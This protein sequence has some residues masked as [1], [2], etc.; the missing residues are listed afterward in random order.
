MNLHEGSGEPVEDSVP[1]S[2]SAAEAFE[3]LPITGAQGLSAVRLTRV[4]AAAS[5]AAV[6]LVLGE[7]PPQR[8]L[9][10]VWDDGALEVTLPVG[11]LDHLTAAG[12]LLETVDG[13]LGPAREGRSFVMRVPVAGTRAMYLML[14]QGTISLAVPWHSVIRIRLIETSGLE[15]MARREGCPVLP[16]FV[17]VPTSKA[18]R[19]AVLVALG[20][21]RG[22]LLA[23]RLVWRMPGLATGDTGPAPGASLG[24]SVRTAGGE[25][26]WVVDP[27]RLLKDVEPAPLPSS[28]IVPRRPP[29]RGQE[30]GASHRPQPAARPRPVEPVLIE[31]RPEDVEPIPNPT[32]APSKQTR[33]ARRAL[34]VEDSIVGRIFL[35]RLLVAQGFSV[36][37]ASSASQLRHAIGLG[38]WD[39]LFVDVA[40]PDS[41]RGEHLISLAGS[42]AVALVRDPHDERLAT[43]AGVRL[44]LRKPFERGELLRV[45]EALGLQG[46]TA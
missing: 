12:S 17:S 9:S 16:P 10:V 7:D 18:E 31:L 11:R 39:V 2:V 13:S 24:P 36:E 5:R 3:G 38:T 29:S 43:A 44:S 45:I 20:L 35:Q 40:L 14:Q 27:A 41:P 1:G 4:V 26:F 22:F 28:P 46:E 25:V 32:E 33:S 15:A 34:V 21:R 8:P 19:P 42:N 6:D 30:Q 37:S 23:D